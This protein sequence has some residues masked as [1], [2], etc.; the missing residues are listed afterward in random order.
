M[1]GAGGVLWG[2]LPVARRWREQEEGDCSLLRLVRQ[3]IMTQIYEFPPLCQSRAVGDLNDRL[4]VNPE[5]CWLGRRHVYVLEYAS[6][7]FC[8]FCGRCYRS[9]LCFA[10]SQSGD[11]LCEGLQASWCAVLGMES[12]SY[13][14]YVYDV[15]CEICV[16]V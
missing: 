15:R 9:V 10:C 5:R 3:V 6:Y 13:G 14:I 4:I 12:P 7:P 11:V 1:L 8:L 16:C 2:F